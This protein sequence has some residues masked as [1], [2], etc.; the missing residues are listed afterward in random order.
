[1][2]SKKYIIILAAVVLSIAG[3]IQS[4]NAGMTQLLPSAVRTATTSSADQVKTNYRGVYVWI[5][6]TAA[7]GG[8]TLT[9]T[10]QG[11]DYDGTYYTILASAASAVA[12]DRVY[13]VF[14]EATAAANTIAADYLPDVWRVTVTHSAASNFTYSV[15]A[16]TLP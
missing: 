9:V 16:T 11:K 6:V 10:I 8:D 2:K 5:K 3:T 15:I 13:K 7:P 12:S 4:A 1:M 14:P